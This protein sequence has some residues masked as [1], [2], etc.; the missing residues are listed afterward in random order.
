MLIKATGVNEVAEGEEPREIQGLKS[1]PQ[2][3]RN[4]VRGQRAVL[5]CMCIYICVHKFLLIDQLPLN[6]YS[7]VG[8]KVL[9]EF[10]FITD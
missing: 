4:A 8:T 10:G 3:R 2:R 6:E 1:S 5:V 7:S 9:N